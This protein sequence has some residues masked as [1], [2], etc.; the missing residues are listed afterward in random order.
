MIN[1]CF[2]NDENYGQI[3]VITSCILFLK[4][5]STI[6]AMR[7]RKLIKSHK[8]T[9]EQRRALLRKKV[10]VLTRGALTEK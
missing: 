10:I 1:P 9:L 7:R 2:L 8:N 4:N 6:E 3:G 5:V